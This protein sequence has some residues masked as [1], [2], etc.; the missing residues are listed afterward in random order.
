MKRKKMKAVILKAKSLPVDCNNVVK[1]FAQLV[2]LTEDEAHFHMKQSAFL[3]QLAVQTMPKSHHCLSMR[4]TV[5]FFRSHP[6]NVELFHE[7]KQ[8]FPLFYHYIIFS[9][10]ILAASVVINSTVVHSE[11]TEKLVFHL[12]TDG[13][14]FVAM[15]HW[16]LRHFFENATIHVLNIEELNLKDLGDSD[17]AHIPFSDEFRVSVRNTERMSAIQMRTEY[18]SVFSPAHFLLPEIFQNLERVIV[19]GDDVV[20]QRDLSPLWGL[21]M[22][23]K[24]N[25]AVEFCHVRL[26]QMKSYLRGESFNDSTCAWMSGLNVINL[27]RWRELEVTET[28]RRLLQGQ[29][30]SKKGSSRAGA[31]PVVLLTF[32]DLIYPLDDSWA[33]SGLGQNYSVDQQALGNAAVLHYN[34]KLKPW[35]ELGIPAY[36]GLWKKYLQKEDQYMEDCNVNP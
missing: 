1:K 8:D 3:Y 14:N 11:E 18:L 9:R 12:I 35:L 7:D 19:L 29:L 15:K 6:D 10:N 25:G 22:R 13:E 2:D 32:Q 28:Y 5:E 26:G 30:I 31:L 17:V 36:K 23:G 27:K 16:F 34:G 20:V 21:D 33:I 4:L 24:V